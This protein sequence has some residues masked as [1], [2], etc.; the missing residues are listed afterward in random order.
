MADKEASEF[1]QFKALHNLGSTMSFSTLIE[2][3]KMSNLA[4]GMAIEFTRASR[5]YL[6]L[7]NHQ[8]S[9]RYCFGMDM[10]TKSSEH[11][12][13]AGVLEVMERARAQRMPIRGDDAAGNGRAYICVPMVVENDVVGVLFLDRPA[14]GTPFDAKDERLADMAAGQLGIS[15]T[16][17]FLYEQMIE[18]RKQV[19]LIDKVSKA[20]SSPVD[21]DNVLSLVVQT[22]GEALQAEGAALILMQDDGDLAIRCSTGID[23][24]ILEPGKNPLAMRLIKEAMESEAPVIDPP[25]G[26]MEASTP[27]VAK[28]G[29]PYSAVAVPVKLTLRDKRLFNERRRTV[30]TTPFTK[31]LGV[32]YLE[33]RSRLEEFT[34][35][36]QFVLQVFADH[37][38]TAVTND[39]LYQQ[40]ST[41]PLTTLASRRYLDSRLIDEVDFA[42][43]TDAPL[44]VIL[45]DLDDF[46]WLNDT[47]GHQ[48][49]DEILRQI[50]QILKRSVRKFDICGRYGGEEF[51]LALPETECEGARVVAENIR[52]R[53]ASEAFLDPENPVLVTVSLGVAAFPEHAPD[54]HALV[55][56][57]DA[58]LYHAKRAGKNRHAVAGTVG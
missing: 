38:T 28:E 41:D 52:E 51:I 14:G 43:K 23:D 45:I 4:L 29:E 7:F 22:A 54:V 3:D 31:I 32:L 27:R 55:G 44:S 33:N 58:A 12:P 19:E 39:A 24:D 1:Q 17:R 56:A 5:G 25:L 35:D 18:K 37:V 16:A 8:G 30:Y 50:G 15:I 36:N 57:A 48:A 2:A 49:G 40:A 53:V 20:V 11:Q 42:R 47:Y 10:S 34:E 26:K 46:K 6:L 9:A 21:L 13:P